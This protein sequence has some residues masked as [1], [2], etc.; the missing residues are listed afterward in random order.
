[1][2]LPFGELWLPRS[3]LQE[4]KKARARVRSQLFWLALSLAIKEA[5][6]PAGIWKLYQNTSPA[7]F[8]SAAE[9]KA[10]FS[11]SECVQL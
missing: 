3:D 9:T 4:P 1:M 10:A 11:P 2:G 7:L 6:D 8:H 5:I